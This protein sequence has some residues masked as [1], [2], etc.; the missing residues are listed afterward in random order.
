M[1]Q[2]INKIS[3]ITVQDLADYLRI[4]E[5]TDADEKQ[6][7]TMLNSAVNYVADYTGH[8]VAELD[9]YPTFV[10]AVYVLVEDMYDNRQLYVDNN[11]VNAVVTSILG[12]HSVNLL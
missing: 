6:L 7:E 11:N 3:E 10:I 5:L 4:S 2:R 9:A 8:T 1:G 12:M